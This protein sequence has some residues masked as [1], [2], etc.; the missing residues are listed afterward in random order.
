MPIYDY[1]CARCGSV[2]EVIIKK[3]EGVICCEKCGSRKTKRLIGMPAIQ[4]KTDT[5][6]PRI[7]R[8]VK[9]Y[10]LDGK[11]S[12]ATRFADKAASMV[13]SD[14]IKQIAEKLHKKTDHQK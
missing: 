1:Q 3:N 5:A 7:E 2:F 6:S 11:F 4:I 8:R 12:A 9:D 14:R 10:L 13:K